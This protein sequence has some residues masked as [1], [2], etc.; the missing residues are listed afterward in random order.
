MYCCGTRWGAFECVGVVWSSLLVPF[1]SVDSDGDGDSDGAR[2]TM[3]M[4]MV[5]A[6][7][8]NYK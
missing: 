3:V 1:G 5:T 7:V 6:A 2:D 4:V 8:V